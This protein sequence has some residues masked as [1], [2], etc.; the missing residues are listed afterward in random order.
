MLRIVVRNG[1]S[2][3]MAELFLGDLRDGRR[4][5]RR[6]RLAD[7]PRG[8]PGGF[9]HCTDVTGPA[10][11]F[12]DVARGRRSRR[13]S[14][15][16]CWCWRPPSCSRRW[17]PRARWRA[18][19]DNQRTYHAIRENFGGGLLIAVEILVAADLVST[20][21]VDPTL[22]NVG[23]LGLI[24]LIRTFLSFSLETELEG[25][26]PGGGAGAAPDRSARARRPSRP[27]PAS[28]PSEQEQRPDQE[29]QGAERRRRVRQSARRAPAP[30][31][32]RRTPPRPICRRPHIRP[33]SPRRCDRRSCAVAAVATNRPSRRTRGTPRPGS[34]WTRTRRAATRPGCSRWSRR[35]C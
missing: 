4:L 6:P 3:D 33:G 30:S 12:D 22:E 31:T 8:A 24:V 1:F 7:A 28:R 19:R 9:H 11:T 17:P 29:A 5:P 2:H 25:S 32:G 13:S 10:M 23:V 34:R 35:P 26:F 16:R 27:R 20:V 14:S 21:A 15:P 18:T